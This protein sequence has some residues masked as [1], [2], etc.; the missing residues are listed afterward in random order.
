MLVFQTPG[1]IVSF[2]E[3]KQNIGTSVPQRRKR[4]GAGILR[5]ILHFLIAFL[6]QSEHNTEQQDRG[7]CLL[8]DASP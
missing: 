2:E 8:A 3:A 6:V 5:R 4:R 1:K 7:D